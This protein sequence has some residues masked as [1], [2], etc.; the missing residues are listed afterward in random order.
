MVDY[1]SFEGCFDSRCD[2]AHGFDFLV[3]IL[4]DSFFALISF[5]PETESGKLLS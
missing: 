5:F 4:F 3:P 2:R 1:E